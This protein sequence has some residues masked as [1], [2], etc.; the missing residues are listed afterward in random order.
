MESRTPREPNEL[1][2]DDWVPTDEQAESILADMRVD[3]LVELVRDGLGQEPLPLSPAAPVYMRRD[4]DRLIKAH[5]ALTE[6]ANRAY[7][8]PDA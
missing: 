3:R 5:I 4:N 2:E 7:G 8:V 1:C 6:L